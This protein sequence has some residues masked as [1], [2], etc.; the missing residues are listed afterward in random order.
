MPELSFAPC[1]WAGAAAGP[2]LGRVVVALVDGPRVAR[3]LVGLLLS[4]DCPFAGY[5]Y[6]WADAGARGGDCRQATRPAA[7]RA[8]KVNEVVM[9][10]SRREQGRSAGEFSRSAATAIAPGKARMPNRLED[11]RRG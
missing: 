2:W 3:G 5:T 4:G 1:G 10:N 7:G 11:A 9:V 6:C 8:A